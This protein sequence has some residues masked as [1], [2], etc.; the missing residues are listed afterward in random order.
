VRTEIELYALA[1]ANEALEHLRA[2]IVRG[3]AVLEI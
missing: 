2:G 1:R 3:A